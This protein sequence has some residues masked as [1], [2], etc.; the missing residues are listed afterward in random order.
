MRVEGGAAISAAMT[1]RT[2]TDADD[3][4]RPACPFCAAPWT[5]AMLEQLDAMSGPSGCSCCV[6]LSWPIHDAEPARPA[7]PAEDLCCAAC[8]RA[9]Y[10]AV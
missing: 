8:G 9:I 4:F 3:R 5:D 10:R 7:A 1:L 6:G 2:A